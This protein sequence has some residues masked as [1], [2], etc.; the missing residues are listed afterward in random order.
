MITHTQTHGRT[1]TC[2]ALAGGTTDK[3]KEYMVCT[4]DT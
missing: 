1:H 4:V 3:K 2:Y